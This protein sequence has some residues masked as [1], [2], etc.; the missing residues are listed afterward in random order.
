[1]SSITSKRSLATLAVVSGL[2]AAAGP[3]HA[4]TRMGNADYCGASANGGTGPTG[5][6]LLLHGDFS[7]YSGVPGVGPR[8]L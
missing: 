5:N 8:D 3:A 1:M 6:I 4:C 7:T 2:L